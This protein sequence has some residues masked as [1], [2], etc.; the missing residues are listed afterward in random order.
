MWLLCLWKLKVLGGA[1][2]A[3]AVLLKVYPQYLQLTKKLQNGYRLEP[4]GSHGVWG[5]D[6]YTFLPF[7]WGSAQLT[8]HRHIRPKSIHSSDVMEGYAESYMYLGAIR[9]IHRLKSTQALFSEHSPILNDIS[10]MKTWKEVHE[11][12][13]RMY[14]TEVL[15]KLPIVQHFLFGSII[16][17]EWVTYSDTGPVVR[18]FETGSQC[19]E[20]WPSTS[21]TG[22]GS[23][24]MQAFGG[25]SFAGSPRRSED[26]FSLSE[27]AAHELPVTVTGV[28]PWAKSA[29][30]PSA[31]FAK[32]REGAREG[33]REGLTGK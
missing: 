5:L 24:T 22:L 2:D 9:D 33:A 13:L 16:R 30:A 10:T 19:D 15:G 18:G 26:A 14:K 23:P 3:T 32:F 12:F 28:A 31:T 11:G 6:D 27:Q 7:V 29:T 4:A 8:G 1:E 17:A 25:S 20:T 21:P